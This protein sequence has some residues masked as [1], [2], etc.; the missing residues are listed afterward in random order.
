MKTNYT[1]MKRISRVAFVILGCLAFASFAQTAPIQFAN[2]VTYGI[3]TGAKRAEDFT[4]LLWT[5][6]ADPI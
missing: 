6:S 4:G 1:N 3:P 5:K 2:T